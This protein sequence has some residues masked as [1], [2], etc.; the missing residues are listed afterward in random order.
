MND[1][2][3]ASRVGV[4]AVESSTEEQGAKADIGQECIQTPR[5]NKADSGGLESRQVDC[6]VCSVCS[7]GPTV[8]RT[9]AMMT[10][11]RSMSGCDAR[12]SSVSAMPLHHWRDHADTACI[13]NMNDH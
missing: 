10:V 2:L 4:R 7:T 8:R 6:S 3:V 1:E 13:M 5:R 11:D 12:R 9:A